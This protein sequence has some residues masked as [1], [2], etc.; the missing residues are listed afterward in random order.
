MRRLKCLAAGAE[1]LPLAT[2]NLLMAPAA[3]ADTTLPSADAVYQTWNNN[4]LHQGNGDTYYNS[5]LLSKGT[6][7][8]AWMWIAAPDIRALPCLLRRVRGAHTRRPPHTTPV[9]ASPARE[10]RS[11]ERR[12]P[13]HTRTQC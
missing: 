13:P 8:H 7:T 10:H 9:R 5:E 12:S 4:F 11:R 2:G 6:T 1:T 3:Q